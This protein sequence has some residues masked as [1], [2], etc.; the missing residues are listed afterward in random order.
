M[1]ERGQVATLT[2]FRFTTF[3][4][5]Y[6][7]FKMMG[8]A[9]SRLGK[10]SG[11]VFSKLMGSGGGNGFSIKPNF[12]VYAFF[13]VWEDQQSAA[14]FFSRHP[15]VAEFTE[16]ASEQLTVYLRP[17]QF[18]GKWQGKTLFEPTSPAADERPVAVLTRARIRKRHIF[19]FWREVPRVSESPARHPE[20][21]LSMGVGE[22]PLIELTTFSIWKNRRSMEDFA[23]R[24]GPHKEV[25]H[26]AR[27][28]KW[29]AED[30]FARFEPYHFEGSWQGFVWDELQN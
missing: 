30:L 4:H 28:K 25:V 20:C 23:Y 8:L 15:K 29:F 13:A 7:A 22:Y 26:K 5:K 27:H 10:A 9:P 21:L 14:E 19:S 12:S 18:M 17:F 2:L 24:Q 3:K 1:A 16:R 11:L 6:W